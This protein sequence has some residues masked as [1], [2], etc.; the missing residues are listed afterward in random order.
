MPLFHGF[1]E[2]M[3]EL[4]PAGE[5]LWRQG[6]AGDVF[7]TLWYTR[8]ALPAAW[9]VQFHTGLGTDPVS[10]DMA[11]FIEKSGISLGNSPRDK[12]RMPGLYTIHLDGAERSFSYWRETSAARQ[13]AADEALI[14]QEMSAADVIYVSGIT[15]AIV[16]DDADVLIREMARARAAGKL[17]AFDP[18]IRPKLWPDADVMRARLMAAG[19]AARVVLPSFDDENQV[20]GDANT[21]ETDARYR[22]AGATSVLVKNGGGPL[23]VEGEVL[24]V[25]PVTDAV[26]TTGAGDSF[27]GGYLSALA[28][29]ATPM[30]AAQQA[31]ALS[32]RVIRHPGALMG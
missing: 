19:G 31:A 12:T 2:C 25:E 23:L 10:A 27:N 24:T 11:E 22:A 16:G 30:E 18:N 14:A 6:F 29:G 1:G 5:K 26:D 4:Q 13:L 17:V 3:V 9:D 20:F 21:A 7:N 32:A 8:R 15:L 28:L